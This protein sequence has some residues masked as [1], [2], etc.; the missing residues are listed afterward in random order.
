[1]RKRDCFA[2]VLVFLMSFALLAQV[3]DVLR[4]SFDYP[5]GDLLGQ[6]EA[7]NGWMGPWEE[8]AAGLVLVI[9]GTLG[10][11]GVP[12]T[13]G[14][15]EVSEAG[16]IWRL[17][18]EPWPDDGTTYWISLLY[19]RFDGH[20]VD[21]SFN[22][23]SLFNGASTELLYIGKPW[24]MKT[25][26]MDAH[27]AD[28]AVSSDVSAY[29][30]SWVVV[31]LVMNGTP[32]NDRAYLW[33][34][35]DPAVEP[36]T[37]AADTA[38]YWEGSNGFDR[39]RIGS[40]NSPTPCECLYDEICLS[41]TYAGLTTE[42]DVAEKIANPRQFVL[43]GNYPNP[44]NPGTTIRYSLEKTGFVTLAVYDLLGHK[45]KEL[46]SEQ[47]M[48]GEYHVQWDGTNDMGESLPSGIYL[49]KLIGNDGVESRKMMLLK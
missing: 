11:E 29:E 32:D 13:G 39:V 28:G 25:V 5:E 46:V 38:A 44:F 1:M 37:S 16:T 34:N 4:E 17:F 20:D 24:A 2:V 49:Y 7:G 22:G 48:P 35:P 26:G 42:T 18:E 23:F 45:I 30:R 10:Y 9:G 31:K 33:V 19:E 36:D 43:H 14:Y 8:P 21:D 47:H 15:L 41:K 3:P 27:R 40:G 6:G 12:E